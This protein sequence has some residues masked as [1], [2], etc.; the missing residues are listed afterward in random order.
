MTNMTK[1]QK[2]K[3]NLGK[4]NGIETFS[5]LSALKDWFYEEKSKFN[6]WIESASR[7]NHNISKISNF[8][9]HQWNDINS[10]ISN[11]EKHVNSG[12][13]ESHLNGLVYFIEQIYSEGKLLNSKSPRG[14]FVFKGTEKD[15]VSYAFA[16]AY[17]IN[18]GIISNEPKS[19]EGAFIALQFDKGI[20]SNIDFEKEALQEL[21]S[22][23]ESE[24][25][26]SVTQYSEASKNTKELNDKYEK[27]IKD[28]STEFSDFIENK[29]KSFADLIEVYDKKL[30]LQSSTSYWD[31]KRKSHRL[32]S[33]IFG[34]ISL[35]LGCLIA[36]YLNNAIQ[37]ILQKTNKPEYW[38][39]ITIAIYTS[40][41]VWVMR[42]LVRIFLSNLHL[43]TDA[44]E[45]VTMITTYIAMLRE[46]DGLKDEEK[47]L[48]LQTVFRPSSTGI[49]KD[50][51]SPPTIVDI[52]AK[53][54]GKK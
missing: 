41:A 22:K 6:N 50:E 44:K 10:M 39:L 12:D 11:V 33:I 8:L 24:Y 30:A 40:L 9:N 42:I 36:Y 38:Q 48:I 15:A 37:E 25:N 3:L 54:N 7:K 27:Q 46:K 26:S 53:L 17:F 16:L 2:I 34:F 31:K 28:Q 1:Q 49:I 4:K 5:D 21:R 35:S 43:A 51:A 14:K 45:R 29:E 13:F 52:F 32:F 47:Q 19:L 23:W 18:L 20:K